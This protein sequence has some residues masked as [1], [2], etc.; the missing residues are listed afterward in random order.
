[1][2]ML[3]K[4]PSRLI[5]LTI[6]TVLSIGANS[7]IAWAADDYKFE[8]AGWRRTTQGGTEREYPSVMLDGP[9]LLAPLNAALFE[10][11]R[12]CEAN[13]VWKR[14]QDDLTSRHPAHQFDAANGTRTDG[15][16][17]P[18]SG[19]TFF[20]VAYRRAAPLQ[21]WFFGSAPLTMWLR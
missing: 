17:K 11:S 7:G 6:A 20:R 12:Q 8:T 13:L 18:K 15:H 10:S 5:G 1:M 19:G 16:H 9:F 3:L 4:K 14:R 21:G 2:N